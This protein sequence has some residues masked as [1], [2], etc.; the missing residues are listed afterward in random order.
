MTDLNVS[1]SHI[2]AMNRT[3]V[4]DRFS[5]ELALRLAKIT[6][7]TLDQVVEEY[8]IILPIKGDKKDGTN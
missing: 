1:Q 8:G 2:G 3:V 4:D 5:K 7:K 6:S